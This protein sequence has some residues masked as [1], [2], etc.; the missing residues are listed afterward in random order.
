[1][2]TSSPVPHLGVGERGHGRLGPI[3]QRSPLGRRP[4]AGEA[5]AHVGGTEPG[6]QAGTDD[7]TGRR[8][9]EQSGA[10]GIP[11]ELVDECAEHADVERVPDDTTGPK[12][13]GDARL[14][15]G[16]HVSSLRRRKP[17]ASPGMSI[18]VT[19]GAGYIGSHTVRR[20]QADGAD[21]VV[22]DSLEFGY[23]QSIPGVPLVVADITDRDAVLAACTEHG[24]TQ[25]VHFAAYKSVDES[26]QQPTRYWMN[27]VSGTV[28][29]VDAL[30]HAGVDQI[31]FSSSCSVHGTP[32][33]VPVTE[34]MPL[35][36]E[37]IYAES[38]AMVERILAWYGMTHSVR[39]VSLRYFNAAGASEDGQFGEVWERSI[40]LIPM[41]MKA[42]LGRGPALQ[43]F[44][45]DY[46]TP[47]GTCIRD[48][49]H[50]DDL[51]DAHV[52]AL[53]YLAAGGATVVPQRRNGSRHQR[54]RGDRGHR[55]HLRR[56][57]CPTPSSPADRGTRWRRMP[58]RH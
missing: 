20:L 15:V 11:A 54:A 27:N 10:A 43:V 9:D 21:V 25:V 30:L 44:G 29:L 39:A 49:I 51:A 52:R 41:A 18:L 46:P 50:V 12:D 23:P 4:L 37:S 5:P 45:S 7:R 6:A 16:G 57:P 8:A 24:V 19:G 48:Y 26:M 14:A 47:D 38:K 42:A 53:D 40:N 3:D 1:M 36:P 17:L 22:L 56:A 34:D 13:H 35:T 31:V 28:Q 32:E 55:A 2:S 58:I 33:S